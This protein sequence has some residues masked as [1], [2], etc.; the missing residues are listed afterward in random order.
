MAAPGKNVYN[1]SCSFDMN[2]IQHINY[3]TKTDLIYLDVDISNQN[4]KRITFVCKRQYP[5]SK[6]V[7]I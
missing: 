1:Q 5:L 7:T 4:L 2:Y 3:T 6:G